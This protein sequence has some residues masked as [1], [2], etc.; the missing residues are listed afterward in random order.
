MIT[1]FFN[2]AYGKATQ[3]NSVTRHWG[4]GIWG[5][6][7]DVES[8]AVCAFRCY[9]LPDTTCS[10]YFWGNSHCQLGR[11][12]HRGHNMYG[13]YNENTKYKLR[14][15]YSMLF[16]AHTFTIFSKCLLLM[17]YQFLI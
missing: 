15:D 12:T 2:D 13:S 17:N 1:D 3:T 11:Y 8:E 14:K 5:H 10:F 16:Y 4:Y 9:I 7:S 6:Y